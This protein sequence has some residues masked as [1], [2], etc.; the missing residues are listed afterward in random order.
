MVS[1]V[2]SGCEVS[3]LVGVNDVWNGKQACLELPL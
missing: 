3:L 1:A 2:F